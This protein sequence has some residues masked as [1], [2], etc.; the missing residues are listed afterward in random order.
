MIVSSS[1]TE[2]PPQADGRRWVR[3]VHVTDEGDELKY[4]W[5]GEQDAQMVLDERVAMLNQQYTARAAARALVVGSLIPLSILDFRNLFGTAK[6]AVDAFNAKYESSPLLTAEQKDEI[7]S[8]MEDFKVAKY[9]ERPYRPEVLQ[10][11]A[12]YE[13]IG[14]LTAEQADA[15]R[16]AGNG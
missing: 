10:Q 14:I 2:G 6:K 8:G 3:E 4:E 1:Y 9:I 12:L 15:V 13:A 16:A 11:I 7:R 5:L